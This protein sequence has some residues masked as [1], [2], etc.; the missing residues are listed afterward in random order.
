[1]R[2]YYEAPFR[3]YISLAQIAMAHTCPNC[4]ATFEKKSDLTRH[5]TEKKKP[6]KPIADKL[7]KVESKALQTASKAPKLADEMFFA[8]DILR[9]SGVTGLDALEVVSAIIVLR[10]IDKVY[11]AELSDKG[12]F[13]VP[14]RT[15]RSYKRTY[16]SELYRFRNIVK[17]N[18]NKDDTTNFVS[19][20]VS[21]Y[22]ALTRHE[23][24]LGEAMNKLNFSPKMFPLEEKKHSNVTFELIKHC[25][26]KL[27]F[28]D[29]DTLGAG[30]SSVIKDF[31]DGK[32]LG[33]FFTSPP[34]V[35]Y[36][37]AA[38]SKDRELGDVLD[39]TCG[40]GG[41]L[42]AAKGCTSVTGYEIDPKVAFLAGANCLLTYKKLP[43][44]TQ[45][46]FLRDAPK[47]QY[48]TILANPPFGI[49]GLKHKDL[50]EHKEL[51]NDGTESYPFN[52]TATGFFLQRIVHVLKEG[53]RAAVVLPLG[54]EISG[55][56]P[57]ELKLRT[58]LL[59]ACNVLEVVSIP[60]G[61]F[62]NTTIKT[63][64]VVFEK[65]REL[66]ACLK[67]K[68]TKKR[69]T[70]EMNTDLEDATIE[71][72]FT[73]MQDDGTVIDLETIPMTRIVEKKYSL[74]HDDYKE[75]GS[76]EQSSIYSSDIEL[77]PLKELCILV[78]GKSLT[79]AKFVSGNVP[80]V[81]GG[82]QPMGFHSV[83]NTS[84]RAIILSATGASCGFVNRYETKIF[85]NSD[86]VE[87]KVTSEKVHSDY[88]YRILKHKQDI[89]QSLR[90]GMAQP[91]LDKDRLM[92][93][94]IPV[95]S[96]ETQMN[97]TKKLDK[98]ENGV[99]HAKKMIEH[100]R[101]SMDVVLSTELRKTSVKM[102]KIAD[103]CDINDVKKHKTE[104]GK[105][106]GKIPFHTGSPSTQLFVDSADVKGPIIILN[107]TNGKGISHVI[108]SGDCSIATQT[109]TL[110]A[111][112]GVHVN[113]VYHYLETSNGKSSL[114]KGFVGA[115]HKNL[116]VEYV[117]SMDIPL[118]DILDQK[119]ISEE[120]DQMFS[121]ITYLEKNEERTRHLMR[122]TLNA[123]LGET[124]I[125]EEKSFSPGDE[126]SES[127]QKAPE[128]AASVVSEESEEWAFEE[129]NVQPIDEDS[130]AQFM[131]SLDEVTPV[132]SKDEI[133]HAKQAQSVAKKPQ[134]PA[135]NIVAKNIGGVAC[136]YGSN[137]HTVKA[138]Q[139]KSAAKR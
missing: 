65:K 24:E 84:E 5:T 118:P 98:F 18:P 86:A 115:L 75:S 46:D 70:M 21:A 20:I 124:T 77:F 89:I 30:Y 45:C 123:M 19:V 16:D 76:E 88:M 87:A 69:V 67:K 73:Q 134:A 1:M 111:K 41:F 17:L 38:V 55:T 130:A 13:C 128:D 61:M 59:K 94:T 51:A 50:V 11:D 34:I 47:T 97:I 131:D 78:P 57:N 96:I 71:V 107:R 6:C 22:D 79:K 68:T 114:E 116:S 39:P 14:G 52:S 85:R 8:R 109:I 125:T 119:R 28:G 127:D 106:V 93:M 82:M 105:P 95:P 2:N 108:L 117:S 37:V 29:K 33:Q 43:E 62:E 120:L 66:L 135:K 113:Y 81:G 74:S 27:Q 90:T 121:T 64:L 83:S 80:V 40:S 53:G 7:S 132:E 102:V 63:T 23:G 58:A 12:Q 36:A 54:K 112:A 26:E 72:K 139:P 35:K 100:Y 25:T 99:T 15:E 56:T 31:L 122:D 42:I 60:G 110:K 129:T 9:K 44:I 101:H 10:E 3:A 126:K 92:D 138:A 32:E 91:H 104:F 49:K 48:D 137:A 4:L 136:E 103:I 133:K